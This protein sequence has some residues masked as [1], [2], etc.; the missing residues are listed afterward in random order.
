M[1]SSAAPRPSAATSCPDQSRDGW[2]SSQPRQNADI[3]TRSR[4]PAHSAHQLSTFPAGMDAVSPAA[5]AERRAAPAP[6]KGIQQGV[7]T[8]FKRAAPYLGSPEARPEEIQQRHCGQRAQRG[9]YMVGLP[10]GAG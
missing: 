3:R 1:E 4:I 5:R 9:H 10:A 7:R 8:R 6:Q 2:Q